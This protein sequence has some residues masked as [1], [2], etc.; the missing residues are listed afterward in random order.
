MDPRPFESSAKIASRRLVNAAMWVALVVAASTL[1]HGCLVVP[2][3]APT[4]T[5]GLSGKMEKVNLDFIEAG[6]TGRQE[7]A[8]KLGATDTGVKENRLFLGR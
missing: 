1:C 4:H 7:V 2:V 5:N 8:E 6:K 3:R